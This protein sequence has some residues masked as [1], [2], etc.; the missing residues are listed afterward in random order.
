[1]SDIHTAET[2]VKEVAIH[3]PAARVFEALTDPAQRVKWWG[4]NYITD[5][6][7]KSDL[8]PGGKWQMTGIALGRPFSVG[9]E[10]RAIEPPTVLAFTMVATWTPEPLETLVRFDLEEHSG[11]T[12]VR[13]TQTGLTA[14]SAHYF[15]GWPE[16]LAA[17]KAHAE[18]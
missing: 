14:E 16:V 13:L 9:G 2:I 15:S 5:A 17:L 1:M 6:R 4:A 7:M 18:I 3:A 12:T 11:S 8:R 10:Y